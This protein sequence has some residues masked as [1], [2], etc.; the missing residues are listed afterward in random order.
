MAKAIVLTKVGQQM[1]IGVIAENI[2]T[3][4]DMRTDPAIGNDLQDWQYT[5]ISTVKES[6]NVIE[7]LE[8]I[9]NK[10]NS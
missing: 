9:I 6:F 7:T 8:E 3:I 4:R 5:V 1:K 10:I 2:L